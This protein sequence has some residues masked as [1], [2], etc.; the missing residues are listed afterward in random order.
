M[1][2]NESRQGSGWE[3]CSQ[4][5]EWVR[6]LTRQT[7]RN[8][9]LDLLVADNKMGRPSETSGLSY[10]LILGQRSRRSV[11]ECFEMPGQRSG[12]VRLREQSRSVSVGFRANAVAGNPHAAKWLW[13]DCAQSHLPLMAGDSA[14]TPSS[15]A[16]WQ[17]E[18]RLLAR[19]LCAAEVAVCSP[20][21]RS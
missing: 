17:A 14:F 21:R 16:I 7:S 6:S 4:M 20:G 12:E 11:P 9:G 1:C 3:V 10:R 18:N 13:T 8:E 19:R 5:G 15:G 2:T